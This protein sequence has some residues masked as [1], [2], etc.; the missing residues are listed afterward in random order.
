MEYFSSTAFYVGVFIAAV[1]S[2]TTLC[3]CLICMMWKVKIL[4]VVQF[5][6]SWF[7]IFK[8]KIFGIDFKLGWLPFGSSMTPL[9]ALDDPEERNKIDPSNL[10]YALFS[11]PKYVKYLINVTPLLVCIISFFVVIY[12]SKVN[13]VA[14]TSGILDFALNTLREIFRSNEHRADFIVYAKEIISGKNHIYFSFLVADLLYIA[15]LIPNLILNFLYTLAKFSEKTKERLQILAFLLYAWIIFWEIPKFIFSLF[16]FT[17]SFIYTFSFTV[18]L[19]T[20]GLVFFFT[21][22]FILKNIEQNL[23]YKSEKR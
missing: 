18:G 3:F 6:S 14:G 19:F 17:K 5:G 4:E 11:K 16:G 9:G 15:L 2:A 7:S 8:D 1:S 21:C 20:L 22:V 10:Q 13:L 12:L 23:N